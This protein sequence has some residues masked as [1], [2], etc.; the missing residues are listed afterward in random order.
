MHVIV[1]DYEERY[2]LEI[3]DMEIILSKEAASFT[4]CT[5][6]RKNIHPEGIR[7]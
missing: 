4:G 5:P 7:P 3:V 1:S 6:N 2:I